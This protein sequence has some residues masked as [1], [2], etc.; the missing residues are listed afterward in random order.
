MP[1]FE[2]Y[3]EGYREQYVQIATDTRLIDKF[4]E[5]RRE[6]AAASE[7]PHEQYVSHIA[8]EGVS[9]LEPVIGI[10]APMMNHGVDW[11]FDY[12]AHSQSQ[13]K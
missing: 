5:Y 11:Y 3:Y 7:F 12:Q 1:N 8:I 13:K 6:V 2:E 10:F 4:R 9:I